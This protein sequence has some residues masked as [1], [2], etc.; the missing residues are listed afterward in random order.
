VTDFGDKKIAQVKEAATGRVRS[1]R[2]GDTLQ[3]L[4]VTSVDASSVTLA[5]AGE[6]DVIALAKF[7]ASGRV[8]QPAPQPAPPPVA[9]PVQQAMQQPPSPPPA[10]A[11]LIA[12]PAAAP[13]Q[14]ANQSPVVLRDGVPMRINPDGTAERASMS[15]G[16]RLAR[17]RGERAAAR[18]Q[19]Q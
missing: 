7:T 8:P 14:T 13:Q 15:A 4:A 6:T 17:L 2:K 11:P 16:E 10:A 18:P 5:F 12:G 3:E 9:P 19:G 1:V